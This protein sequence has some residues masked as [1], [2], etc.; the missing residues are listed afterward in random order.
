MGRNVVKILKGQLYKHFSRSKPYK[1]PIKAKHCY[2]RL[3]SGQDSQLND[4]PQGTVNGHCTV[5]NFT[6]I[7]WYVHFL[8]KSYL[9]QTVLA[10]VINVSGGPFSLKR[11]I[12]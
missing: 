11:Y 1:R 7:I 8:V 10:D 12:L 4:W 9:H 6:E 5:L 2:I 3:L